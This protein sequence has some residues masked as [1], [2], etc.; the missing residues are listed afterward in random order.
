MSEHT[1]GPWT[2][3]W[4]IRGPSEIE[5]FRHNGE[6]IPS[7]PRVVAHIINRDEEAAANLYL[8]AA[9]PAL[10]AAAEVALPRLIVEHERNK[11]A[12]NGPSFGKEIDLLEAAISAA[13]ERK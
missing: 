13:K 2:R 6:P 11:A 9:A 4:I 10:L 8:I 3:D 12:R 7:L 1:K 5:G